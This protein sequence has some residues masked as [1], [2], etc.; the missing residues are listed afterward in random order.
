MLYCTRGEHWNNRV[1]R[2]AKLFFLQIYTRQESDLNNAR[3]KMGGT[4]FLEEA[5]KISVVRASGD[6]SIFFA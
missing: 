4:F 5:L 6:T 3:S 1:G 2:F